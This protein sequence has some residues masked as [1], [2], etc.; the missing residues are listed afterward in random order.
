MTTIATTTMMATVMGAILLPGR[1]A[2]IRSIADGGQAGSAIV[3]GDRAPLRRGQRPRLRAGGGDQPRGRSGGALRGRLE[4]PYRAARR[5][6]LG[7]LLRRR[8]ARGR[9]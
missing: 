9:P 4:P 2:S 5:G 3:G 1:P 8:R 7:L 6:L